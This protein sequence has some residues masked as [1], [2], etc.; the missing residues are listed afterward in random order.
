MARQRIKKVGISATIEEAFSRFVASATARGLSEKT[1]Q[2][3]NQHIH[4]IG[5]HL[6][7]S[8]TF[9]ELS[10]EDLDGMIVSMRRSGL[11]HNS[12]SS[13]TRV[14]RTFLKWCREQGLTELEI[15]HLKD[16]ET[17]KETYTDEELQLLLR[18]PAR[19]S[20]FC[21]YR[22]WVIENFFMNCGCRAATVRSIRNKDVNFESG[23]VVFRHTKNGKVQVIPLCGIMMN[24]LRD[25]MVIRGGEPNDYLFP[26]EFGEMLTE[27]ALRSAIADYNNSRGVEKTSIHLFRHTFARKYL[28]DCGGDAFTLQKLLGHSTLKMTKHYCSIFDADISK[29]FDRFSPLAQMNRPKERVMKKNKR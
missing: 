28:I 26:S 20:S 3:Y 22:N 12:I 21:E 16:K 18:K 17:V 4:S 5:K 7:L 14:F 25:Y 9:A 29:N 1:I 11:A 23:Q 15:P 10:Q 19:K 8:I 2:T 6:D 27:S 24:I 13:Y